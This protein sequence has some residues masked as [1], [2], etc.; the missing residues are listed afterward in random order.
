MAGASRGIELVPMTASQYGGRFQID[1]PP[2]RPYDHTIRISG[3]LSAHHFVA[4]IGKDSLGIPLE[5][6]PYSA[7][8]TA[9][10]DHDVA[11]VDLHHPMRRGG[12]YL[13]TSS[14]ERA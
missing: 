5:R 2:I 14:N 4:H 8:T 7:A 1:L 10:L 11:G 9:D 13:L 3:R 6:M 12:E